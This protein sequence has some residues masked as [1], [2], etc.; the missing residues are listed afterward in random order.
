MVVKGGRQSF[1]KVNRRGERLHNR[2]D[3]RLPDLLTAY[4][5]RLA[6]ASILFVGVP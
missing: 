4:S 5:K 1:L 6:K 3:A 2:A